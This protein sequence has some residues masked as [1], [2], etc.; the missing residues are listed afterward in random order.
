MCFGLLPDLDGQCCW[1]AT[2]PPLG[3]V[4]AVGPLRLLR[5]VDA[6]GEVH[7]AALVWR[8]SALR[9][10]STVQLQL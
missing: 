6:L 1:V 10:M 4:H 2:V 7:I 5:Y 9:Q 8:A 3:E